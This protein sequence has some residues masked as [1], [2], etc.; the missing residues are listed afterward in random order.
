MRWRDFVPNAREG[1]FMSRNVPSAAMSANPASAA[2]DRYAQGDDRAFAEVYDLLAPRLYGFLV[3]KTGEVALAED[4]VQQTL[5]QIHC[6]RGAYVTGADVVPWAFAIARRVAI[7]AW[8]RQRR[9]TLSDS[10]ELEAAIQ[11][12]AH[13][14]DPDQQ[15]DLNQALTDLGETFQALPASQREAFVLLKQDGLSLVQAADVL[16][17]TVGN[18]KVRAHRAYEALRAALRA[19]DNP[20]KPRSQRQ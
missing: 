18:V 1:Q 12:V 11:Y 19:R 9:E 8:R 2:M 14:L 17:T 5:L 16:G 3:R 6:A 15:A 7:D 20:V 13:E 10:G 4:L